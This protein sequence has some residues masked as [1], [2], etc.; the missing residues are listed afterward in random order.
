MEKKNVDKSRRKFLE[1][2]GKVAVV[3]PVSAVVLTATTKPTQAQTFYGPGPGDT[4]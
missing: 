3:A 2:A 4:K 1:Q